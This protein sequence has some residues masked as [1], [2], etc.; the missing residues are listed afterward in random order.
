[1]ARDDTV[2][3]RF[4][5]V[6]PRHEFETDAR[7]HHKGRKLRKMTRRSRFAA[8]AMGQL[9]GDCRG[10]AK[11][12]RRDMDFASGTSCT[13]WMHRRWTCVDRC[14]LGRSSSRRRVR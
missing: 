14:I 8:V 11:G 3:V 7:R 2:L 10:G 5:K 6:V 12:R 1:M 13:R 4:L 9:S